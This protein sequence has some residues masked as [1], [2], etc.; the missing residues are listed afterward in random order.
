M[1]ATNAGIAGA[2]LITQAYTYG[3]ALGVFLHHCLR[4]LELTTGIDT[5]IEFEIF[6][7]F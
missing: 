7:K 4:C 6:Q 3:W 1:H 5:G 2:A